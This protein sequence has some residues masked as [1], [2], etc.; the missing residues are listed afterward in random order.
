MPVNPRTIANITQEHE[1]QD[2]HDRYMELLMRIA[3]ERKISL[4]EAE[5]AYFD[6]CMIYKKA[7]R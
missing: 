2:R 7:T 3:Q 4:A 6:E 5:R 1:R